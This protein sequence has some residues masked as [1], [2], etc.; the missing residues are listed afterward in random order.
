MF[1]ASLLGIETWDVA[2]WYAG[3]QH[4]FSVPIRDWNSATAITG[5]PHGSGF[6]ASLLGIETSLDNIPAPLR[7]EVFSVPIR[8]WN[9]VGASF[10]RRWVGLFLASLLGIETPQGVFAIHWYQVRF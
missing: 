8:D 1:L 3:E 9:L 7:K 10:A 6:L 2:A 4:V 5:M